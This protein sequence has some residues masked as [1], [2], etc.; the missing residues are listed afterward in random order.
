MDRKIPPI[1]TRG[2]YSL[3]APWSAEPTILYTCIAIREFE[4]LENLGTNVYE[5]YYAPMD[6]TEDD[7]REDQSKGAVIVTLAS[8][9]TAPIYIPSSYIASY[10]NLSYRN[11]QHVVLSA[12]LGPLPDYI[13]MTFAR[14]QLASVLAD[15]IGKTPTVN[16]SIAAMYGMVSPQ[17]HEA[18]EAAR[19]AAIASRTTDRAKLLAVQ[20]QNAQLM[21]RLAILENICKDN[22]LIP[23]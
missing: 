18:L 6:L 11:Y 4:D 15:V 3:K 7:H 21:Q 20:Q 16:V 22:G 2:I 12:S 10:P 19:Q 17:E 1:G 5:T 8:D 9:T 14:E 23:A 13:D